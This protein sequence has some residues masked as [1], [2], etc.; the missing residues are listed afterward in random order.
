[1]RAVRAAY[2]ITCDQSEATYLLAHA[3]YTQERADQ[4]L[5]AMQSRGLEVKLNSPEPDRSDI[6]VGVPERGWSFTISQVPEELPTAEYYPIV[7]AM[8]IEAFYERIEGPWRF[9]VR[10]G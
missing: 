3:D 6:T 1:M 9:E 2:L 4:F 5:E 8:Q 7:Y 10:L